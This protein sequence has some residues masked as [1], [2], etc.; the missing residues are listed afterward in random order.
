MKPRAD[1]GWDYGPLADHYDARP[2]YARGLVASILRERNVQP[3][4]VALDIGAGTGRLTERLCEAGLRVIALEPNARMRERALSK[5]VA[6]D[7]AWIAASGEALPCCG[8]S[9][10]LVAFGSSFNVLDAHVALDECARVLRSG[11]VWLAIWNHRDLDDPLQREIEAIIRRHVPQFEPGRRRG[12]PAADVAAH[13]A[14][15]DIRAHEQPFVADVD[16][17]QWLEAWRSHATLQRQAGSRVAPIM[18]DIDAAIPDIATVR[19]PYVSRAWSARRV[20]R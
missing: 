3:K 17:T 15:D 10:D 19:V 9:V 5:D 16:R 20:P 7:A 12:S 18:R 14:F 8:D 6:R 4:S 11:G 1:P 2:H 13:G